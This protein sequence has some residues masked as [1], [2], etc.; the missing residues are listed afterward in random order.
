MVLMDLRPSMWPM[1]RLS[2]TAQINYSKG[3]NVDVL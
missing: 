3:V 1:G 2:I